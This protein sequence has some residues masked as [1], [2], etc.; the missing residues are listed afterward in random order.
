MK[1]LLTVF[2]ITVIEF[3]C[4]YASLYVEKVHF[5]AAARHFD[6]QFIVP[7]NKTAYELR[8]LI[9][10]LEIVKRHNLTVTV[11][12]SDS[13]LF[14]LKTARPKKNIVMSRVWEEIELYLQLERSTNRLI[15]IYDGSYAPGMK[16]PNDELDYSP[17]TSFY[18]G[19]HTLNQELTEQL[20]SIR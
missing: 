11:I 15:T 8:N 3:F 4:P 9:Q 14:H 5:Y 2:I 1:F 13:Y 19:F 6:S 17:S 20:N 7:Q 10:E 12:S 18:A 16:P